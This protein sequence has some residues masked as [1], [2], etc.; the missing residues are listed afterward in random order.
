MNHVIYFS[1]FSLW[2][3]TVI[4]KVDPCARFDYKWPDNQGMEQNRFVNDFCFKNVVKVLFWVSKK[5]EVD[6]KFDIEPYFR[7]K[8]EC[9]TSKN[10]GK[11]G[12]FL[13][14]NQ[15]TRYVSSSSKNLSQKYRENDNFLEK[16][17]FIFDFYVKNWSR[18]CPSKFQDWFFNVRIL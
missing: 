9:Q 4:P 6:S 13:T 14:L 12:K 16:T 5:T 11:R 1:S 18:R 8:Y 15:F 10:M 3:P 2:V 7:K 17:K